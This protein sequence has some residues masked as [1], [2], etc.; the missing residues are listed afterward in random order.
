[1]CNGTQGQADSHTFN[2]PL[3]HGVQGIYFSENKRSRSEREPLNE[4]ISRIAQA[5][6]FARI[7][8]SAGPRQG[9]LLAARNGFMARRGRV[10]REIPT[11]P[12]PPPSSFSPNM[13]IGVEPFEVW[14]SCSQLFSVRAPV[15]SLCFY[16][17]LS[18]ARAL[19][20]PG[21]HNYATAR[22]E[23]S[24]RRER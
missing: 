7:N 6:A 5:Q 17:S 22:V 14:R 4:L 20:V 2:Y 11:R 9:F 21:C 18:R 24:N 1:M 16:F 23:F 19:F 3:P 12:L 15:L 10:R 13:V 8:A